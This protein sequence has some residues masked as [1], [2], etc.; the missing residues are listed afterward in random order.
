M[1]KRMM[2]AARCPTDDLSLTNCAII[3]EKE[4]QFEQHVTVR[5][6]AHRYVFTLK[7][8]SSVSPGTIAFSLPQVRHQRSHR[9]KRHN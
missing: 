6:V 1:T 5:N 3:N 7:K 8:D 2:Q 9:A 4:P